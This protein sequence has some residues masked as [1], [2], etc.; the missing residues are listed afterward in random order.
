MREPDA[1]CLGDEPE[2]L[3]V[4]VEAPWLALFCQLEARFISAV[5]DLVAHPSGR[6]FVREFQGVVAVPL[7]ANDRY[8]CFGQDASNGDVGLEILESHEHELPV[9]RSI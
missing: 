5:Q 1:V 2:Q 4:A 3:S 8:Q 9:V 6:I 7:D